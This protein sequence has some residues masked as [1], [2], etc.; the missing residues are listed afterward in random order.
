MAI[1]FVFYGV[2]ASNPRGD[3]DSAYREPLLVRAIDAWYTVRDSASATP[4]LER[5]RGVR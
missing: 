1:Q 3:E 4:V 5:R 2:D